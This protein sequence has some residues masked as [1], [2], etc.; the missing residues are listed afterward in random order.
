MT[1]HRSSEKSGFNMTSDSISLGELQGLTAENISSAKA[2]VISTS[3]EKPE[4]SPVKAFFVT[5]EARVFGRS[6]QTRASFRQCVVAVTT[7]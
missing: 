5:V 2:D 7:I 1:F 4:H 6:P 3:R